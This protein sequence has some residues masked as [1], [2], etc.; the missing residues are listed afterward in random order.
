M[1]PCRV[2]ILAGGFGTRLREVVPDVPKP[3]APIAGRPMLEYQIEYL[4][5]QGFRDFTLLTGH[6]AHVIEDHFGDGRRFGVRIDYRRETSPLGTGGAVAAA[7]AERA[8]ERTLVLNG[9]GL[10]ATDYRRLLDLARTPVT[11]ALKYSTDLS[12]YGAV[13]I[14]DDYRIRAFRE[15]Q[16]TAGLTDGFINAGAYVLE[17]GALELFPSGAHSIETEVFAPLARRGALTGI[18]CG[19]KF[20]DI[21]TPASYAWSQDHLPHWLNEVAKPCLFLDRDGVIVTHVSY[22]H[23]TEDV[24][25]VEPVVDLMRTAR[26]AG[27]WLVVTTNQAGVGRGLFSEG[28]YRACE[29]FIDRGLRERGVTI[30]CWY[31][32]FTHPSSGQGAYRADS[33][34]RKPGPGMLLEACEDLPIDLKRSVFVGDNQ[35]DQIHLPDLRVMLVQGDFKLEPLMPLTRVFDSASSLTEFLKPDLHL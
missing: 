15:K 26:A 25:F 16:S 29:A 5:G 27:W 7:L 14:D 3:M 34:R 23:R 20:V 22:L 30:D 28:Q 18:P 13:E 4:K 35:T 33:L 6:L 11:L 24:E 10:F 19:G 9:D 12:R 21:G 8:T 1:T 32:C 31:A 17:P 2:L